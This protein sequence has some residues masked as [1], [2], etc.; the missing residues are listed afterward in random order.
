MIFEWQEIYDSIR[1]YY[2]EKIDFMLRTWYHVNV[3][4][5]CALLGDSSV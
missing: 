1:A 3:D 4:N 2:L 5:A